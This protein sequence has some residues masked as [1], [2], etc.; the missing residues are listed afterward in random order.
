METLVRKWKK[1]IIQ[2]KDEVNWSGKI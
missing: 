1:L 2:S